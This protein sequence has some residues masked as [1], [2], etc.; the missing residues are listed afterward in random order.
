MVTG[1]AANTAQPLL[2]VQIVVSGNENIIAR[3]RANLPRA[4]LEQ[5][6]D[7][8][9]G[10]Y[11]FRISIEPPLSMWRS[12]T[13]TVTADGIPIPSARR[14]HGVSEAMNGPRPIIVTTTGR[15]GSSL[16]MSQL[17]RHPEIIVGGTHP[18]EIKLLIYYALALMLHV[19]D[20]DRHKSLDPNNM[21]VAAT[22]YFIGRNPFNDPQFSGNTL[23]AD[24]WRQ[25]LPSILRVGPESL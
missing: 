21:S 6:F 7:R 3:G 17:G 8:S 22:R 13:L 16:L 1:W 9:T 10:N 24:Y 11:G 14:V 4:D 15:S 2:D 19:S 5:A 23:L 20:G 25:R 12:H 18:Y